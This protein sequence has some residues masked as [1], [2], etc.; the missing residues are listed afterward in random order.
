MQG[1]VP[2]VG[3]VTWPTPAPG[4]LC[5]LLTLPCMPGPFYCSKVR[6]LLH[7]QPHTYFHIATYMC[8]Y[9]CVCLYSHVQL[10]MLTNA[11]AKHLHAKTGQPLLATFSK[12]SMK[13][14]I[15]H[16]RSGVLRLLPRTGT[17]EPSSFPQAPLPAWEPFTPQSHGSTRQQPSPPWGRWMPISPAVPTGSSY[18]CW[19]HPRE[20]RRARPAMP[21]S[22]APQSS[23]SHRQ[24]SP[25]WLPSILLELSIWEGKK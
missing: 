3:R 12:T 19:E 10:Q 9:V 7:A 17:A 2:R 5:C 24:R 15:R 22:P 14:N 16:I 18:L 1:G 13:R 21:G 25:H 11:S 20:L 23:S 8:A 6:G 4:F